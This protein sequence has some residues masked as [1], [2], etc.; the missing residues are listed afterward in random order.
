[1]SLK[2]TF[3]ESIRQYLL[4]FDVSSSNLAPYS[5]SS[6]TSVRRTVANEVRANFF[7]S[8]AVRE[9]FDNVVD[10]CEEGVVET[11]LH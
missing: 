6:R 9:Q 11:K 10:V 8:E 2:I 7:G 4:L 3:I 1:M 5:L